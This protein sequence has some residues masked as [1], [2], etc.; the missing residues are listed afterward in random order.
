MQLKLTISGQ[1]H[2]SCMMCGRCCRRFYVPLTPAEQRRIAELPWGNARPPD[3]FAV[4][5]CGQNVFRRRPEDGGCVFLDKDGVC[6][7]HRRFGFDKK[8]LTC[9]GYPYSIVSTFPGEVSALA[10]MDCPAVVKN[11]GDALSSQR[12]DI[13]KLMAELQFGGGFTQRQLCG[14]S[15]LSVDAICARIQDLL[16]DASLPLADAVTT[17]M[18]LTQRC[19]QLGSAFLNDADTMRE[20][21]HSLMDGLKRQLPDLPRH[22]C[23]LLTRCLFRQWMSS[24]CRRD[25]ER[26]AFSLAVRLGQCW[27]IARLCA[28]RGNLRNFG[29][30]HTDFPIAKAGL[31]SGIQHSSDKD[32]WEPYVRF[33]S[34]RLECY[35]FFGPSYYG[36]DFFS[37][38]RALLLS[39]PLALAFCRI[40]TAARQAT[41]IERE[42]VEHA[43]MAIDHT[44][45]R[46]NAIR[47]PSSRSR[48]R[49][50]ASHF[51]SLVFALGSQ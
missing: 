23:G 15:R 10:R 4:Q 11:H 40:R 38:L 1:Q 26:L 21:W 29:L 20:V 17:A 43:V 32:A 51:P 37:G 19:E 16:R 5:A 50:L 33:L 42:D 2:Y 49:M 14:L 41:T 45:G 46:S 22:D 24:Y 39:Y 44:H 13:E 34:V 31:F 6:S 47:S 36:A 3:N 7:M 25:E 12:Q 35:Q 28:G 48:E 30:E 18:L 27:D 8:A 9:R